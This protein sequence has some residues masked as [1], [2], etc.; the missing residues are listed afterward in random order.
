MKR[1]KNTDKA[2]KIQRLQKRRQKNNSQD[3]TVQENINAINILQEKL[4]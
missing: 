4:I 1:N 2:D 3:I